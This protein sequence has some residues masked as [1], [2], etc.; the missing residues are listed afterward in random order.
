[1]TRIAVVVALLATTFAHGASAHGVE[2]SVET[3]IDGRV[4]IGGFYSGGGPMVGATVV[5]TGADGQAIGRESTDSDGF[6]RLRIEP[7]DYAFRIDDGAGHRIDERF[8]LRA[9]QLDGRVRDLIT[10]AG[11]APTV[12]E[13]LRA[14]PKWL[15]GAVGIALI[16]GLF[17]MLR[18][19]RGAPA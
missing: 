7:G 4:R 1:M 19:R 16:L 12:L 5:V 18:R 10:E 8:A 15:T 2:Y 3:T 17:A 14:L 11:R 9:H 6:V 13:R